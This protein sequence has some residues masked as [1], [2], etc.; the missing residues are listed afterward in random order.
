MQ[1]AA[2][3][4]LRGGQFAGTYVIAEHVFSN[5]LILKQTYTRPKAHLHSLLTQCTNALMPPS[6]APPHCN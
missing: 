2:Q 3:Y 6:Y 1:L 5:A 4:I